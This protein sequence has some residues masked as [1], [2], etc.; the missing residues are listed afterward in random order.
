MTSKN[1]DTPNGLTGK[2]FILP[3][4]AHAHKSFD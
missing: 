4:T 3:G 1:I 2:G